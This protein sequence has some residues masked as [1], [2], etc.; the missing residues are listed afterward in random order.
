MA[1][2][3]ELHE[4]DDGGRLHSLGGITDRRLGLQVVAS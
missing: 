4:E 1:V 2:D 3:G